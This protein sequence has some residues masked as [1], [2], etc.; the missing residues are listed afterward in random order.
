MVCA[1]CIGLAGSTKAR[2][3]LP[4]PRQPLPPFSPFA[5][6]VWRALPASP[7]ARSRPLPPPAA[8]S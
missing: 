6:L 4:P 7:L 2:A 1:I 8:A 3:G 5:C